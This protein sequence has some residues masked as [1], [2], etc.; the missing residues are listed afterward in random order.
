MECQ[1]PLIF[2]IKKKTCQLVKAVTKKDVGQVTRK[3]TVNC[4]IRSQQIDT[5]ILDRSNIQESKY[6]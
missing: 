6:N 2:C 3:M 1:K 4:V 5:M